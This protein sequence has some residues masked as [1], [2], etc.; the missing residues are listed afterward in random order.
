MGEIRGGRFCQKRTDLVKW[1]EYYGHTFGVI[2]EESIE[3]VDECPN[4]GEE[5]IIK[6]GNGVLSV[7]MKIEEHIPQFLPINGRKV[8]V[9]YRG[10]PK[11]CSRC[12][13]E[14]HMKADCENTFTSWLE[15]VANFIEM[16]P[17]FDEKLFG[18][19]RKISEKWRMDQQQNSTSTIVPPTRGLLVRD[20]S[21]DD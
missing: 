13:E 20:T 18:K 7:K 19:W 2:E 12:Y 4:E 10:M 9:Y 3:I 17:H 15:Y 16:H 11:L 5:H 1:L 6:V 8:K 21:K 14:G